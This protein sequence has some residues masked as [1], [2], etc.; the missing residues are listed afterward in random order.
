M[1]CCR[2]CVFHVLFRV[3]VFILEVKEVREVNL[4]VKEVREVKEVKAVC[5]ANHRRSS[6]SLD[7]TVQVCHYEL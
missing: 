2:E 3:I 1:E 7:N 4:G 6:V 5:F